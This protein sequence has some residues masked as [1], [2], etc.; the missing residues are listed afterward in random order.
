MG[1]YDPSTAMARR[2]VA[3]RKAEVLEAIGNGSLSLEEAC[4]RHALTTDEILSWR[5]AYGR[6]GLDGLRAMKVQIH[7]SHTYKDESAG[8]MT[9]TI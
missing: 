2:W 9:P 1:H 5:T 4:T 6:Y 8:R 7:R 3:S